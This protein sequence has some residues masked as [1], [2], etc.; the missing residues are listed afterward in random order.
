MT[1]TVGLSSYLVNDC[2]DTCKD[3][4]LDVCTLQCVH[5]AGQGSRYLLTRVEVSVF[6]ELL[7]HSVKLF[8][9]VVT[10]VAVKLDTGG[11]VYHQGGQGGDL[12]QNRLILLQQGGHA[13]CDV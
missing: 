4:L 7:S 5:L 3:K 10:T 2:N 12:L 1:R 8:G 6:G 11:E 9:V 13:S